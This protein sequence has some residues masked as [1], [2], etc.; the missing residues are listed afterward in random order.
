M[1]KI[2]WTLLLAM[3]GAAN[4]N[5][6]DWIYQTK[7][8]DTLWDICLAY[9][10]KRGCWLELGNYN[11]IVKDKQVAPGTEI[12]IPVEWLKTL[13]TVASIRGVQGE[14]YVRKANSEAL[15]SAMENQKIPLG[16]AVVTKN[17]T[18]TLVFE[19]GH[20]VLVR[21]NSELSI[22]S[23]SH[24]TSTQAKLFLQ[25]GSVEARVQKHESKDSGTRQHFQIDT[26]SAVAAVRG[27]EFRIASLM[28]DKPLMR[29][30]VTS[31]AIAV[32]AGSASQDIPK[33]FGALTKEGQ[34][35]SELHKL[36]SA[37]KILTNTK[38]MEAGSILSWYP[39]WG[40]ESYQLDIRD[41]TEQQRLIL[42]NTVHGSSYAL[43]VLQPGCYKAS[44][45][46]TDREGYQGMD[47]VFGLCVVEPLAAPEIALEDSGHHTRLL[48]WQPVEGASSYLVEFAAEPD[49]KNIFRQKLVTTS[50][51][52][53]VEGDDSLYVRVTAQDLDNNRAGIASDSLYM[54][55][56]PVTT[57][58]KSIWGVLLL[59]LL[60]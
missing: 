5:A 31:G 9:T 4:L 38:V 29:G 16:A 51:L 52:E 36:L 58:V 6:E 28:A 39:L 7:P 3:A 54:K 23:F 53:I 1:K 11:A 19:G 17:G 13:P 15:T 26:P 43:P 50:S 47:A 40:A 30:E 8:G 46:A 60:L 42:T 24:E 34:A 27:T 21:E 25:Q 14:V 59:A 44:L 35:P 22:R 18:A 2:L 33:G 56:F 41:S 49:F 20:E 10:H 55:A 57:A 37:P 32:S 12:R 45:R 48:S